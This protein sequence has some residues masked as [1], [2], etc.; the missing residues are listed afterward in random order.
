MRSLV[1]DV[2]F[3]LRTLR[4]RPAFAAAATLAIALGIGSTTAM[5]SVVDGVLLRPLPYADAGRL[6]AVFRTSPTWRLDDMLRA[7]WDQIPFSI[8]TYRD[9]RASQTSFAEVGAWTPGVATISGSVSPE[10]VSLVRASASLLPLLG[11]HATLGRTF[12]PGEDA[13]SAPH[14]AV[15]THEYWRT[16]LGSDT[17]VLGR[18]IRIDE[19][20]YEVIGV[21]PPGLHLTGVGGPARGER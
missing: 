14:L 8:A 9:W 3:V 10:Q 12:R 2:P 1:S 5:F 15:V 13:P 11:V 19:Q 21:L 20:P 17:A 4:R 16:R 6:V 7:R 18:S